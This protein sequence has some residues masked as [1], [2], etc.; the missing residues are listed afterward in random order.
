MR[1]HGQAALALV[2]TLLVSGTAAATG[3]SGGEHGGGLGHLLWQ[4]ANLLL[5]IGVLAYF[6]RKPLAEY[7]EQ[8]REGIQESL[9]SSARIL[10]QAESKLAEWNDRAAR[11]DAELGEIRETSRRLVRDERDEILAQ[12]QAT[13]ERIRNDAHAAVEQE[14][15][16][17]R[18][19]LSAEAAELAVDLAAKLIA[20]KV[21]DADQQ[22]LF[23][24]F[25]S[26]VE[27]GAEGGK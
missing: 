19:E 18:T 12:A 17:A 24:E 22:R 27:A 8:R 14:L 1:R 10:D 21:S 20:E 13:A 9:E 16:R 2:A 7:L 25:L 4:T 26:R 3:D 5:I 15:R 23:D 6:A 11:L